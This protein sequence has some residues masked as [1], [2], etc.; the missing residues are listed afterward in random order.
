MSNNTANG[1][2]SLNTYTHIY[3]YIYIYIFFFLFIYLFIGIL[4]LEISTVLGVEVSNVRG[5][6][7]LRTFW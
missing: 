6:D 2:Y 4:L 3:R 5:E 1:K 7:S